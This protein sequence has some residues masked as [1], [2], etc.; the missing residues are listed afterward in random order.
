MSF[1]LIFFQSLPL[2]KSRKRAQDEHGR[3]RGTAKVIC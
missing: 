1:Q 3:F 2:G